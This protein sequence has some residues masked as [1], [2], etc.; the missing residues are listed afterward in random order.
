M[1]G[2]NGSL[3][4]GKQCVL[5]VSR[6]KQTYIPRYLQR[7]WQQL[8]TPEVLAAAELLGRWAAEHNLGRDWKLLDVQGRVEDN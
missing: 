8:A 7:D 1:S 2:S 5:C 3:V 4:G 6:A